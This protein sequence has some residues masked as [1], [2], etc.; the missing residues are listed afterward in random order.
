MNDP[1]NCEL[2]TYGGLRRWSVDWPMKA[3]AIDDFGA[4]A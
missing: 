2:E 1:L 3:I 4:P